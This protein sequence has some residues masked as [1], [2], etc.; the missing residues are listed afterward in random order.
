MPFDTHRNLSFSTVAVAPSPALSGT[1]LDIQAGDVALFAGPPFNCTICATGVQPSSTNA[2]IVRVTGIVGSTLTIVRAQES[3]TAIA[4]AV[5]DQIA[6]TVTAKAVQDIE[7]AISVEA[8]DRASADA[9]LVSALDLVSNSVSVE[10]AARIAGVDTV[11]AAVDVVENALSNEISVRAAAVNVVSNAVSVLSSVVIGNS[12]QMTS[13]DNAISAAVNALSNVVSN[14]TSAIVANSAQMTSADN[15][16]SA[17]INIVS[18]ALSNE[19]SVRTS[20]VNA[21]SDRLSTWT[22]DNLA[23]VSVPSPTDS[24]VLAF[25]SAAGQWVA[26]T[27]AAGVGSVTSAEVQAVSVAAASAIAS[28]SVRVDVNST[29][30]V[31]ADDAISAAVNA[32]SAVVSNRTSAI[33]ANSAQMTSADNAISAAGAALSLNHVSLVSDVGRIS[34]NLSALSTRADAISVLASNAQSVA[35]AA[36]VVAADALSAARAASANLTSVLSNQ[37]SALSAAHVSLVSDVGRISVNLSALSTRAD[38]ISVLASN[39]QSIA[40]AASIVAADARSVG[41]AASAAAAVVSSRVDSAMTVV[42]NLVS[43]VVANS[44]QMTSANNAISAAVNV[45]SNALSNEISVRTSAVNAVS[46]RL[47]TWTLDNLANVSAPSPTT[48]QV[49]AYNSVAGQWVA[50]TPAGGPGGGSVTS[51]EVSAVSAAALSANNTISARLAGDVIVIHADGT[52]SSYWAATNSD[53]D[54]GTALM[55]A[56]SAAV[57]GDTVYLG[58]NTYDIVN[59][60]VDLSLAGTGTINLRGS[61]RRLTVIESTW[62]ENTQGCIVVPGNNSLVEHLSIIGNAVAGTFQAPWGAKLGLDAAFTNAVLRDCYLTAEADGIYVTTVGPST[63]TIID[64]EVETNFDTFMLDAVGT[65]YI[66]DCIFTAVANAS[67]PGTARC[68]SSNN[69]LGNV[70]A[71]NCILSASNGSVRNTGVYAGNVPNLNIYGGRITTSGTAALDL[72]G[73]GGSTINVTGDT[74]YNPTKT[75]GTIARI[76]AGVVQISALSVAISALSAVVSN[77]TSAILANS[78]QMTS[79]DNAISAAVNALSNVVSNR[80]S[81]IVANSAQMTSADNAISA[82]AADALSAARAASANLTSVLSNQLSVTSANHVSLVSDV[83]RISLNL[84]A[85]S[86][87]ADAISV[88]ASNAQSVANAASAVAADALSAARAASANI[89][90]VLSNQISLISANHVSLVSD[91]GRISVAVAAGLVS[92]GPVKKILTG[93]QLVTATALVSVSGF[94]FACSAGVAY[95]MEFMLF[96]SSPISLAHPQYQFS[97]SGL[98]TPTNFLAELLFAGGPPATNA[99]VYNSVGI[100]NS[101][102]VTVSAV[103]VNRATRIRGGFVASAAGKLKLKVGNNISGA[104]AGSAITIAV[105]SY[106]YVWRMG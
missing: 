1:S 15:A 82:V 34:L 63:G 84:S 9:L 86:T 65:F 96:T 8:L 54:R 60:H 103:G 44:A 5:G 37:I 50:S 21:V 76:D 51:A 72:E 67:F 106:G 46:N 29:Q 14:R 55:S 94:T 33:V 91:V 52:R 7:S 100:R 79:A 41:N 23:N 92:A 10:A 104:G 61:G 101:A 16:L 19:I 43:A 26:S 69:A 102:M 13:A 99:T 3:T 97:V 25:N 38:A 98:G 59:N 42:S 85:L 20:A 66:Y 95:G 56:M 83:G 2:E 70:H 24:Q 17:A 80:T 77:R 32:L 74:V 31:S 22:L 71:F 18:N 36:S 73:V 58:P 45:V 87:R 68:I 64:C 11:S 4:I 40:N 30:M 75:S 12:A 93:A 35:N 89:T 39:A 57:T 48:G 88:L 78:A 81:A 27:I 28:V 90:S 47:S 53:T 6:M 49:L 62:D 105:G